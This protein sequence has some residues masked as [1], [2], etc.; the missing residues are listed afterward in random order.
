[1]A[2]L[3]TI[4]PLFAL[5]L[6]TPR[7]QLRP[8][9]DRDI[10]AYSEAALSGIHPPE[11]MPFSFPWTD[12]PA[13]ELP[14]NTA[15]HIWQT[16][17]NA[18]PSSWTIALGVWH[19]GELVGCQDITAS[20]FALTRTVTTGSWLRQSVQGR[21]LSLEMRAAVALYAFDYLAA[22]VAE[23][24]AARWN[25]ASLG[26]SRSLG[27]TLNGVSRRA[28]RRGEAVLLQNVRLIP[29]TFRRP[30]WQLNVEGHDAVVPFLEL[31]SPSLPRS[32]RTSEITLSNP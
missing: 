30:D 18:R 11:T 20:D 22:E 25:E 12:A 27:Y 14:R 7:L 26:V 16:R 5:R 15:E 28:G 13:E 24:Q 19:Q 1:M 3:H 32:P 10:P 21:G 4:W 2:D 29:D 23:S 17:L 6:K 31:P 9:E 8:L